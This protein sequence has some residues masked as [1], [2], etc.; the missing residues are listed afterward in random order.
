MKKFLIIILLIPFVIFSQTEKQMIDAGIKKSAVKRIFKKFDGDINLAIEKWAENGSGKLSKKFTKSAEKLGFEKSYLNTKLKQA[1]KVR[2]QLIAAGI[3]GAAAGYAAGMGGTSDNQSTIPVTPSYSNNSSYSNPGGYNNNS[4]YSK[5][6]TS[7]SQNS[8]PT[9][10]FISPGNS[11]I[12]LKNQYGIEEKSGEIRENYTGGVDIYQKNQYG[13]QEKSGEMRD[14]YTGGVDVYQK[15]QYGIQEKSGEMRDNYTGGVDI[16][17]K[18]QYGIQE[19][20]GEM[21]DNYTGGVDVLKKNK[22]GIQQKNMEYR[23]NSLGG[24]DVYKKN[25]YGIMEK[26]GTVKKVPK[27]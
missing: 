7:S 26:A 5:P 17:Q 22:Y 10:T 21:R 25:K 15:N 27:Y 1:R 20:S 19:K 11:D 24:F 8:T 16:Y 3:S 18:N 2:M 12:Y 13:I 4:T 6:L 14:N 9:S 23:K